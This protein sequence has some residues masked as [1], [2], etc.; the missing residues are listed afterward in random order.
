M[1][2]QPISQAEPAPAHRLLAEWRAHR[3]TRVRAED[4]WLSVCGLSWLSPGPNRFGSA[5]TSDVVLPARS[6]PPHAGVFVLDGGKVTVEPAPGVSLSTNGQP[7]TGNRALASD[8]EPRPD[9]LQLGP[10]TMTVLKRGDRFAIRTKDRTNPNRDS[11][12]GLRWFPIDDRFAVVAR[13]Q[14]H[15]GRVL[16]QIPSVVG[17]VEELVSP[18]W[19]E[20]DLLGQRL[21]LEPVLESPDSQQLFFIFR[22]QTNGHETYGGGRFLFVDLPAPGASSVRLDFNRTISPPCAYTPYATCA[23]PLARNHLPVAIPAGEMAPLWSVA[24]D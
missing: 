10:L 22:D 2:Y 7:I 6:A 1:S 4:G 17:H 24:H 23:M 12:P 11:F 20:F 3:E 5:P 9:Q 8:A 21:S 15:A 13:F 19:V 18:G 14:P 16:R